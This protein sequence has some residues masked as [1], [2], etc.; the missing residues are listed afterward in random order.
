MQL[1][2]Q[3]VSLRPFFCLLRRPV[4]NWG[5]RRRFLSPSP[6]DGERRAIVDYD[7]AAPLSGGRGPG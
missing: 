7:K 6:P 4:L 2:S 5:Y 3:A 1:K